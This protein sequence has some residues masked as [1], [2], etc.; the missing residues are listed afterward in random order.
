MPLHQFNQEM[1][2]LG[3]ERQKSFLKFALE[4]IHNSLAINYGNAQLVKSTGEELNFA[5]KFAPFINKANQI[6]LVGILNQA[7]FHIERNAH[8]A[9]LFTDLSFQMVDLME[10]GKKF[11][12]NPF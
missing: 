1:S 6:K 4:S 3:R 8:A 5:Q 11:V 12:K 2:K 10:A 7:I 9:I